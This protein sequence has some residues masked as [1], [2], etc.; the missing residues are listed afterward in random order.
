VAICSVNDAPVKKDGRRIA[1]NRAFRA[2]YNEENAGPVVR[3][4]AD[5]ATDFL[6]DNAR[7]LLEDGKSVYM[8]NLTVFEKCLF[9]LI[10]RNMN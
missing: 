7:D 6:E 3:W 9:G 1:K 10:E 2:L 5:Y 8:P 4:E